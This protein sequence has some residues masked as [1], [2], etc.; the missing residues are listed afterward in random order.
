MADDKIPS[1]KAAETTEKKT[2]VVL[3]A[4]A[5]IDGKD[6]EIGDKVAV[7]PAVLA[8]LRAAGAIATAD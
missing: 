8:D 7:A 2:S 3:T 4:R 6:H 5:R 1:T